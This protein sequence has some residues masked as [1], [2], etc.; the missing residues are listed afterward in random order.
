[1]TTGFGGSAPAT[2]KIAARTTR[3]VCRDLVACQLMPKLERHLAP[4]ATLEQLQRV[5]AR[6]Y[7]EM[8]EA[9]S[10]RA[11]STGGA[12]LDPDTA[13]N[14]HSMKAA[15]RAAGAAVLATELRLDRDSRGKR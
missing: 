4:L 1:M 11:S 14:P 3:L 5:H 12:Y 6:D 13:M 2:R 8:L 15:L 9:A 7:I 10:L